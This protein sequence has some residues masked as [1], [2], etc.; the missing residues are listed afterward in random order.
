MNNVF[1]SILLIWP[2]KKEV[3][4]ELLEGL[5]RKGLTFIEYRPHKQ[6]SRKRII[7]NL[8]ILKKIF[9]MVMINNHVELME[10]SDGVWV[11]EK[12]MSIPEVKKRFCFEKYKIIGKTVKTEKQLSFATRHQ[13]DV[14]GVGAVFQSPTK[15]EAAMTDWPI[16][17]K[18][19]QKSK[20]PAYLVG[21]IDACNLNLFLKN[22]RLRQLR[23]AVSSGILESENPVASFVKLRK[24]IK[25]YKSPIESSN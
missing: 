25:N 1:P 15:R 22:H 21:G 12:D 17:E 4:K 6:E 10:F 19:I 11:G 8:N 23:V 9:P 3:D 16:I 24:L 14:I 13:A 20:M 18:I 7:Q 5:F 2:G